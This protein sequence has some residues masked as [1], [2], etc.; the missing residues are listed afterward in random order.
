MFR[1][2]Y[3]QLIF[4][5]KINLLNECVACMQFAHF[6][7]NLI[8]TNVVLHIS[9]TF[10]M[11]FNSVFVEIIGFERKFRN[12]YCFL[13]LIDNSKLFLNEYQKSFHTQNRIDLFPDFNYP[14]SIYPNTFC[15]FGV[16]LRLKKI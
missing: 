5:I 1:F 2:C 9:H 8:R 6:R 13:E 7:S 15:L 14:R 10:R 12:M 11:I 16:C 4:S 3:I